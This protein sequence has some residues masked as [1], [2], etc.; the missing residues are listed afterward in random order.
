MWYRHHLRRQ[1]TP[2]SETRMHEGCGARGKRAR[3]DRVLGRRRLSRP[4]RSRLCASLR[5]HERV[6]TDAGSLAATYSARP[7]T[8]YP[9]KVVTRRSAG[10]LT[11]RILFAANVKKIAFTEHLD[12]FVSL[13]E[14]KEVKRVK[15]AASHLS[16]L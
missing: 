4:P 15:H 13:R 8:G 1:L 5:E 9:P 2:P 6:L 14:I 7:S 10:A 11:T 3:A 16:K 12:S